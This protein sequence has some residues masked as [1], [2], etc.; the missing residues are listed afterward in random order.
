MDH[1]SFGPW[2]DVYG[3]P[4]RIFGPLQTLVGEAD[5]NAGHDL[6][7]AACWDADGLGYVRWLLHGTRWGRRAVDALWAKVEER[8]Y[9]ADGV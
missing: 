9:D 8:S 7:L 1:P 2:T 3:L 5:V 6:V 4:T